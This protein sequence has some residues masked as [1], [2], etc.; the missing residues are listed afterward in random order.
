LPVLPF[1]AVVFITPEEMLLELEL[2]N[3]V[4]LLK[5]AAEKGKFIKKP[6]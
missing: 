5:Q 4:K 6:D 3:K 1:Y 2:G